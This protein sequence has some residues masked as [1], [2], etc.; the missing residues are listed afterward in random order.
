MPV[1][2][3]DRSASRAFS[4]VPSAMIAAP[5]GA[6]SMKPTL[7]STPITRHGPGPVC[8]VRSDTTCASGS[9][10]NSF[11]ASSPFASAYAVRAAAISRGTVLN[12]LKGKKPACGARACTASG[13]S[14]LRRFFRSFAESPAVDSRPS[15][16]AGCAPDVSSGDGGNSS[17]GMA[18]PR[19]LRLSKSCCRRALCNSPNMKSFESSTPICRALSSRYNAFRS[20]TVAAGQVVTSCAR[21]RGAHPPQ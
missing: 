20:A 10:M 4:I 6:R 8:V 21:S 2:E 12:L 16:W 5:P 9:T 3:N 11:F 18:V 14:S 19:V 1:P 17:S 7:V 13:A 15:N